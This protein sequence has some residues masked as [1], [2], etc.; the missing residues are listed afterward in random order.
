MTDNMSTDAYVALDKQWSPKLSAA[1]DEIRLNPK[2]F[3]RLETL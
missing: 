2:L 1:F 3:E